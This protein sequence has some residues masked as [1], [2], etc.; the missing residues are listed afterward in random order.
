M[1]FKQFQHEERACLSYTLGCTT[2][3]MYAV[4]EAQLNIEQCLE[5]ARARGIEIDHIFETHAK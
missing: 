4:V 3:R 2:K 5:H 1:V